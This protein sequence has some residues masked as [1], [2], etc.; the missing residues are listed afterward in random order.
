MKGKVPGGEFSIF[1][2]EFGVLGAEFGNVG[3]DVWGVPKT[4]EEGLDLIDNGLLVVGKGA[5]RCD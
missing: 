3:G 2:R 1:D 5:E 4:G